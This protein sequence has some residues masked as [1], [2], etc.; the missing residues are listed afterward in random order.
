[1]FLA[2]NPSK[3]SNISFCLFVAVDD[4]WKWSDE[5][6]ISQSMV[7]FS[8]ISNATEIFGSNENQFRQNAHLQKLNNTD[9][10]VRSKTM[11]NYRCFTLIFDCCSWRCCGGRDWRYERHTLAQFHLILWMRTN[12]RKHRMIRFNQSTNVAW[13]PIPPQ[14]ININKKPCDG[15]FIPISCRCKSFL[16]LL[17]SNGGGQR[18]HVRFRYDGILIRMPYTAKYF[19]QF[20]CILI[21]RGQMNVDARGWC[22]LLKRN[23]ITRL[24]EKRIYQ[25]REA[26]FAVMAYMQNMCIFCGLFRWIQSQFANNNIHGIFPGWMIKLRA[27]LIKKKY[28]N[29]IELKASLNSFRLNWSNVLVAP[30]AIHA[31]LTNGIFVR[32]ITNKI[33]WWPFI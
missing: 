20:I 2:F 17:Q 13:M 12:Y 10:C 16:W 19:I 11:W 30:A 28:F 29:L 26:Y 15:V 5:K 23:L 9:K 22:G 6:A 1:M 31:R 7:L 14:P 3:W 32:M 8:S 18:A 4:Y 21:D 25:Q 24:F 33:A 27:E